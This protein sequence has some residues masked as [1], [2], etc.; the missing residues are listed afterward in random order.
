MAA[1]ARTALT[2]AMQMGE[3][4]A[5]LHEEMSRD[6]GRRAT[7]ETRALSARF[8]AE[9][10]L[11]AAELQVVRK[12][13]W[14][15]HATP[16][17]IARVAETAEAWTTVDPAAAAAREIVGQEVQHRFDLNIDALAIQERARAAAD[18]TEATLLLA[19][20]DQLD[21]AMPPGPFLTSDPR[22]AGLSLEA[23][24]SEN[25]AQTGESLAAR[26]EAANIYDSAERRET[27]AASLQ[28]K[29]QPEDIAARVRA[30]VNQARPAQ[31]VFTAPPGGRR[32]SAT[33]RGPSRTRDRAPRGR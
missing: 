30:D 19:Q 11:A 5:R 31:D 27:F 14:W 12:P 1:A 29:A 9:R 33:P 23:E 18:R 7:E 2:V 32:A 10:S 22:E 8:D 6:A 4:L 26:S 13:D 15:A 28:G 17:D 20:A 24:L 16:A 3:K 21:R 25:P